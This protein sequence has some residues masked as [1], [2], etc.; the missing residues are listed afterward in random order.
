MQSDI[1]FGEWTADW[2][3]LLQIDSAFFDIMDWWN[4]EHC[5]NSWFNLCV[6]GQITFFNLT[7]VEVD[8]LRFR[9][10]HS[11]W[12]VI[13]WT[14]LFLAY[15][16]RCTVFRKSVT[17]TMM[18]WLLVSKVYIPI[19]IFRHNSYWC[20]PLD[21]VSQSSICTPVASAPEWLDEASLQSPLVTLPLCQIVSL[22]VLFSH[23]RT[24]RS[25]ITWSHGR[26]EKEDRDGTGGLRNT[27]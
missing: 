6:I 16:T 2:Y 3:R 13:P 19:I 27:Y 15:N 25:Q 14:V 7:W 22:C 11:R 8:H 17:L 24:E 5:W 23:L 26:R 1:C 20:S 9:I 12:S 18:P 4:S 21:S 10:Y